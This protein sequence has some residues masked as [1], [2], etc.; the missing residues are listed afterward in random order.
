MPLLSV[1]DDVHMNE[2]LLLSQRQNKHFPLI[3][4]YNNN[5]SIASKLAQFQPRNL[6]RSSVCSIILWTH[7]DDAIK[8]LSYGRIRK[9]AKHSRS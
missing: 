8:P 5:H 4:F 6:L 9:V 2:V 3:W 7:T 1:D